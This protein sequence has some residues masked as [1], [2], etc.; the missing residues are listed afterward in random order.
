MPALGG[1][2][3][4]TQC[5]LTGHAA[6]DKLHILSPPVVL[7]CKMEV[8]NPIYPQ[9]FEEIKN[10]TLLVCFNAWHIIDAQ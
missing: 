3:L 9:D 8:G 6:L 4:Y 1:I 10:E 5:P 7:R 2:W